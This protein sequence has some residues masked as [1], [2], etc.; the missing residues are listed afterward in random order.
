AITAYILR[1][2]EDYPPACSIDLHEDNLIDEGYVYSQGARG[3][4]DPLALDAVAVLRKEGV[5][6]KMEGT[7]RFD[8]TIAGG[9]I[10]PVADSS[11]DELMS[12]TIIVVDDQ[13]VVGPA[14]STVLVFETPAAALP[15]SQRVRAHVA[16]IRQLD[17]PQGRS[18]RP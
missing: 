10:G 11:I 4:A 2:L 13:T 5:T 8:E 15:L 12:S 6:I 16:L 17:C 3:A 14:A 18:S 7:T 1:Q 9:I